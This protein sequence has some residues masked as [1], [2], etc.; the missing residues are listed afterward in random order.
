[1]YLNLKELSVRGPCVANFY[2][3]LFPSSI[4]TTRPLQEKGLHA[5]DRKLTE[6]TGHQMLILFFSYRAPG[7]PSD[8]RTTLPGDI[9][10]LVEGK[11]VVSLADSSYLFCFFF[12]SAA[13]LHFLPQS[14]DFNSDDGKKILENQ[15]K[16]IKADI[17]SSLQYIRDN[18]TADGKK[19][20]KKKAAGQ[21]PTADPPIDPLRD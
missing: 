20:E 5:K 9:V 10:A 3:S 17:R 1:M 4:F 2:L 12:V 8:T 6:R 7:E 16:S 11:S 13:V 15:K 19:K 14:S 21:R 18:Y